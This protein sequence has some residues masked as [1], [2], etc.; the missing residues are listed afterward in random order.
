MSGGLGV[1][2]RRR[3][4]PPGTE[5]VAAAVAPSNV[6]GEQGPRRPPLRGGPQLAP[7]GEQRLCDSRPR[8]H[9]VGQKGRHVPKHV[10]R[11]R[12]RVVGKGEG[13]RSAGAAGSHS[14][15]AARPAFAPLLGPG[16]DEGREVA[17]RGIQAQR[18]REVDGAGSVVHEPQ[19]R[20]RVEAPLDDL[21]HNLIGPRTV[22][23]GA[24]GVPRLAPA[25]TRGDRRGVGGEERGHHV[26]A[27][28]PL[29]A[30]PVEL[31]LRL[32]RRWVACRPREVLSPT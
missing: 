27:Q 1:R 21:L 4:H 3:A 7:R 17:R 26:V 18:S 28:R 13:N 31:E 6:H 16:H 23:A 32:E 12:V 15:A 29:P 14:A 9:E 25:L 10:E 24:N 22:A 2:A 8:S 5:R 19:L 11:G 30:L 20:S